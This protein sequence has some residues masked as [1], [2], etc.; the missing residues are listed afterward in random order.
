M[1][2]CGTSIN[3]GE[4][5]HISIPV[6]ESLSL[7]AVCFCGSRP[8]ATLTVTAGVHGCEYVGIQ[9]L[10]ELSG[11]LEP[12]V[13]SGNVILLP[14]ANP[15]AFYAGSKQ[16]VPEDGVNLNRAFPG[17]AAGS[18]A[19]RLAH[20]LEKSLYP[21]SDFLAD[22]HSGDCNES[23]CPLVFFPTAGDEAVCQ[24]AREAAKTV[25]V[26]YRVRS[27]AKNGLYSYA[28]Q[29]G[30]PA[31]L[32]ER[33]CQGLWSAEEV[34][35]CRSDVLSLMGHLGILTAN[36]RMPVQTEISETVYEEACACG[37]WYPS[38]AA[39]EPIEKGRLLGRLAASDGQIL[40]EI[41]ASSDGVALYYT[42]ALGVWKGEPLV[43]YGRP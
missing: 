22:L 35:A 14:V 19:F 2:F 31:M 21:V 18:L 6:A 3:P 20:V 24:K 40:Q 9:A 39:G 17:D 12:G 28:V 30:I 10:R 36:R 13:M 16:T 8:G 37:F 34:S 29:K 32:I 5:K 26:P 11:E 41:R 42:T 38:V 43:A 25:D 27:T 23:L 1:I 33:G 4:K 15:S 7:E